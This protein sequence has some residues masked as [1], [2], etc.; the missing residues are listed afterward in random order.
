LKALFE[1]D[2]NLIFGKKNPRIDYVSKSEKLIKDLQI[3]L[4]R[5]GI[6]SFIRYDRYKNYFRLTIVGKENV[7]KFYK[8]INF[9]SPSKKEKLKKLI[10]IYTKKPALSLSDFIPF[11]SSYIK[12]KYKNKKVSSVY[13]E[14]LKK[15]NIDRYE[16]LKKNLSILEKF[17]EK[18][19]LFIIKYF[20]KTNYLFDRIISKE[21]AGK[22]RVYS[23]KVESDCHSFVANGFINHNTEAKLS[24][25][26]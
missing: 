24:S 12:N 1:G 17:L 15:H 21:Y 22:D 25:L 11:L 3:L 26:L 9:A 10:K 18:D 2:G 13:K 4:L 7:T 16:R 6:V 23:L 20:L 14:W 5:F 19:D 8:K